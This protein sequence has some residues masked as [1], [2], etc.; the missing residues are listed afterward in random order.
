MGTR[1]LK[2]ELIKLKKQHHTRYE[3]RKSLDT[4]QELLSRFM[5]ES[6]K[7]WKRSQRGK[8]KEGI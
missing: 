7:K 8:K 4:T 2:K 6:G 5:D 1:Q 3:E